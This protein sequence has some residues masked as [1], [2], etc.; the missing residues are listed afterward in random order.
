M[1]AI[2]P[3]QIYVGTVLDKN[4]AAIKT[5]VSYHAT[6][7]SVIQLARFVRRYGWRLKLSL[8]ALGW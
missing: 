4:G 6:R 3:H 5:P 7:E 1:K 2:F 8:K